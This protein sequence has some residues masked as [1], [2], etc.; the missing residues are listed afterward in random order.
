MPPPVAS[1]VPVFV[2][3]GAYWMLSALVVP[4]GTLASTVAWLMKFK[5]WM[6]PCPW[7]VLSVFTRVSELVLP[8]IEE[9]LLRVTVPPPESVTVGA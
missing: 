7:I 3:P 6:M 1:S 8:T 9:L 5:L 4:P 2:T